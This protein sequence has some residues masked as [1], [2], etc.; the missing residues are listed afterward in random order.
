M[1]LLIPGGSPF[2]HGK[3]VE[4]MAACVLDFYLCGA[5]HELPGVSGVAG[6]G[7]LPPPAFDLPFPGGP[8]GGFSPPGGPWPSI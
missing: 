1:W 4:N 3:F 6:L 7:I 8:V 2:R 5:P